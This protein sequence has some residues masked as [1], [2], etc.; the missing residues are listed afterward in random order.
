MKY[1]IRKEYTKNPDEAII[2]IL[3]DRGVSDI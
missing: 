3:K 1:K 2:E